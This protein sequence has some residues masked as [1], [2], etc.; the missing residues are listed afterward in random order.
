MG[1]YQA[2]ARALLGEESTTA[3]ASF[4]IGVLK[5][6]I[7]GFKVRSGSAGGPIL[8]QMSVENTGNRIL[9]AAVVTQVQEA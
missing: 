1:N 3:R 7:A 2:I 6:Q 9:H 4:T 5:G 8:R